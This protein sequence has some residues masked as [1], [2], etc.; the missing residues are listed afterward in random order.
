[1]ENAGKKKRGKSRLQG[2]K[3]A[4]MP[5]VRRERGKEQAVS[6]GGRISI[7]GQ[8]NRELCQ[9]HINEPFAVGQRRL[10]QSC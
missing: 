9:I 8:C 5:E 2:G 10:S 7:F 4:G 1:M 6:G 3:D